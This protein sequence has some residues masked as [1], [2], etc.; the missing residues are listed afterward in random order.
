M[1]YGQYD[2][3]QPPSLP[4]LYQCR[5]HDTQ[6]PKQTTISNNNHRPLSTAVL[7]SY[8]SSDFILTCPNAP[9]PRSFPLD[10]FSGAV[11]AIIIK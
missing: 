11:T 2:R 10:Q 9:D 8:S 7:L 1:C 6:I 5:D 3:C 4:T